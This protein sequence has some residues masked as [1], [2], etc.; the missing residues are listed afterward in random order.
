[1]I[2]RAIACLN[3]G[4]EAAPADARLRET[5]AAAHAALAQAGQQAALRRLAAEMPWRAT[6]LAQAAALDPD[7]AGEASRAGA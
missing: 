4:L 3:R 5:L 2:C 1:M 7:W 6:A